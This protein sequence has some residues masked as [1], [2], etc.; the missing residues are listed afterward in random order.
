[1]DKSII[2]IL[3]AHHSPRYKPRAMKS[4]YETK[5]ILMV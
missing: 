4:N 5:I 1:M 3:K 2:Y